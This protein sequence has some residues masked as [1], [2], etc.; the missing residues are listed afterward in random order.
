[1]IERNFCNRWMVHVVGL[2]AAV[3]LSACDA[4]QPEPEET[5]SPSIAQQ[6]L[7][8]LQEKYD[9]LAGDRL[10]DPVQWA[11]DDIENI[12]D[13]EYRVVE[14]AALGAGDWEAELNAYGN[15]RW[16]V[17]WVE[18]SPTGRV[19]MFKRPSISLLSKIPLSQLGRMMIGGSGDEQ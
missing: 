17:A 3:M 14:F 5:E 10:D 6:T 2:A 8:D 4:G 1:M 18:A 16:E 19:V 15:D 13:W 11:S 7:K 9:E 12:G